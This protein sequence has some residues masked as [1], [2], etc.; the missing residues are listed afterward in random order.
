MD[1]TGKRVLITGSTAGIGR[2]AAELFH[3]AGAQVAINGRTAEAV[4]RTIRE[5]GGERL[6]PAAAD[7]G[8]VE[9]CQQC[10]EAAVSGMGGLDCLVNNLGI[11]PLARMM[12]V[13]EAHW[14]EVIAVN[15]RSALF[16]TNFALGALRASRGNIVMVSST[17]A[18]MAGPTDSFVYAISKAGLV[19]MTK[20]LALELA[21]EHVRVNCLCPGYIDTPMVR[22]ENAATGGQIDR[23]VNAAVPLGRKGTVRECASSILYLASDDAGYC[24]G[25]IMVNDGGCLANASWGTRP[26]SSGNSQ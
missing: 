13:T 7:V 1:F 17:V 10:V 15:L 20:T 5:M 6:L 12:D 23:F 4:A 18:L 2:A 16:C 22:A 25:S 24:T 11:W 9:G 3:A 21:G 8:T 26:Q 19:G 14:D